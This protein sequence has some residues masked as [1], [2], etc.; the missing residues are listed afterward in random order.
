MP[1][2]IAEPC[3][4]NKDASCTEVCPVDCIRPLRD[5]PDFA[6]VTQLYIDPAECIDCD[7]CV[8]A[9]PVRATFADNRLPERWAHFE[10]INREFFE[11]RAG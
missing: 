10:A 9:C 4:G 8:T 1:Y 7:A 5:D 3:I 2:V 11:T 6:T